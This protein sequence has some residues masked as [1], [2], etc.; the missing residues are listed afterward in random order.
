MREKVCSH[1]N[2]DRSIAFARNISHTEVLLTMMP[3]IRIWSTH[4]C[5]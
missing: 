3:Y 1:K 2:C 4:G 5:C